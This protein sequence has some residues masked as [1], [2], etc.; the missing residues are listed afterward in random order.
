MIFQQNKQGHSLH[1]ILLLKSVVTVALELANSLQA[2]GSRADN[3][4]NKKR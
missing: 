4:G 2:S 3:C 1:S